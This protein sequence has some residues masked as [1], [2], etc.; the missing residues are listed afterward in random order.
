MFSDTVQTALSDKLGNWLGS[1]W[2]S[3]YELSTPIKKNLALVSG[4]KYTFKVVQGMRDYDLKGLES[5]GF[6]LEKVK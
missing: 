4:Q 6:R 3:L 5:V 2:G 1:G